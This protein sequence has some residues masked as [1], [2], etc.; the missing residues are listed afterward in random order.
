[1]PARPLPTM[2]RG[3]ALA[4][5]VS[6]GGA[7]AAPE[8]PAGLGTTI[9]TAK[10]QRRCFVDTVRV[11]GFLMQR[12]EAYVMGGLDGYRIG[13][14]LAH[15]GD[16]VSEDQE[17]VRLEPPTAQPGPPAPPGAPGAAPPRAPAIVL[18]APAG[19]VV[20][21]STARVGALANVRTEPLMRIATSPDLDLVV[22]VPSAYAA[23]VREGGGARILREDGS[24][25]RALVRVPPTEIDARTQF[26]RAHLAVPSGSRLRAGM[27]G[28]AFVETD[29]SCG[30]SVP[31]GAIL[32]QNNTTSV[33]VMRDG[34]LVVRR[35]EIGLSSNDYVEIV[36]GLAEGQDVI[37]N[38]AGAL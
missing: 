15:E 23:R 35:V 8:I 22:D 27:F 28:R 14:V 37:A 29:Q 7:A 11:S 38:A 3:L 13:A 33:L 25:L 6:S 26:A 30:P 16:A 10:A 4:L 31:K 20:V 34:K 12:A 5:L 19:G 24:E 32:R 9:L 2:A 18:R 17:L 21:A 36:S 1:M